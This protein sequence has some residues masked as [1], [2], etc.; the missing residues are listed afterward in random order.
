MLFYWTQRHNCRSTIVPKP[1]TGR[2]WDC[3]LRVRAYMYIVMVAW[4]SG[5]WYNDIKIEKIVATK[6]KQ[7]E[8][9]F[10]NATQQA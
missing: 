4:G 3:G 8:K 7:D 1:M 5:V 10:Y 9:S 6:E 2:C